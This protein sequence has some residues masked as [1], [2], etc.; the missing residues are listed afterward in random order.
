[1]DFTACLFISFPITGNQKKANGVPYDK[2]S[3]ETPDVFHNQS[4]PLTKAPLKTQKNMQ[5]PPLTDLSP[6]FT[7][8]KPRLPACKALSRELQRCSACAIKEPCNV[9]IKSAS[10]KTSE[11]GL[12]VGEWGVGW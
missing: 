12:L 9:C 1:M 7:F 3:E 8:R 4:K 2:G 5:L 10:K 11:G 6:R